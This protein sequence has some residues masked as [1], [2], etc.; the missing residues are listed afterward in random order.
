MLNIGN[1]YKTKEKEESLPKKSV[2]LGR[3][4]ENLEEAA[5]RDQSLISDENFQILLK[6]CDFLSRIL[7]KLGCLTP[8]AFPTAKEIEEEEKIQAING[9]DIED[10]LTDE[11]VGAFLVSVQETQQFKLQKKKEKTPNI[12]LKTIGGRDHKL[13]LRLSSTSSITIHKRLLLFRLLSSQ[14]SIF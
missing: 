9:A 3:I 10:V 1:N 14:T 4:Y 13:L 8:W 12:N 6:K 2:R 11:Y 5:S 7:K